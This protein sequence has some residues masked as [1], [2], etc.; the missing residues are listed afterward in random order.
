MSLDL[1]ANNLGF[2]SDKLS[3][4]DKEHL[5]ELLGN[6]E[7]GHV[8]RRD[9]APLTKGQPAQMIKAADWRG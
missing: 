3:T 1:S 5:F 4:L 8:W 2:A 9:S 7:V 6:R